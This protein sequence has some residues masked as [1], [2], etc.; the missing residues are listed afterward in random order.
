[1][2]GS[3]DGTVISSSGNDLSG[4]TIIIENEKMALEGLCPQVGIVTSE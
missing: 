3:I 4:A 2:N 1:M